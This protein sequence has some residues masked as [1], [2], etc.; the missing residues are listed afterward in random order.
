MA[1]TAPR[2][3]LD[4]DPVTNQFLALV[5]DPGTVSNPRDVQMGIL[6]RILAADDFDAALELA[7]L[8]ALS[9]VDVADWPFTID[10]ISWHRSA[11]AFRENS[12]GVFALLAITPQDGPYKDQQIAITTGATNVLGALKKGIESGAVP[13]T[14]ADTRR[15][16]RFK[17]NQTAQG[18]TA[19]WLGRA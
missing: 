19:Y 8:G 3:G 16:F 17:G 9:T 15:V 14:D 10:E 1:K 6:Q 2:D 5:D 12:I 4:T 18:T 7:D 13:D 11:E